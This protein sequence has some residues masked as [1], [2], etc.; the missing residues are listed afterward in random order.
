MR[1]NFVRQS[2]SQGLSSSLPTSGRKK[3]YKD[4]INV[5][6]AALANSDVRTAIKYTRKYGN[7]MFLTSLPLF[8]VDKKV[9]YKVCFWKGPSLLIF[10]ITHT[11]DQTRPDQGR[12]FL[13]LEGRE[14]ERTWKRGC[15]IR[16]FTNKAPLSWNPLII[17]LHISKRH[18]LWFPGVS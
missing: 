13:P 14:E 10:T 4:K 11:R 2:Y 3:R 18:A 12:S 1:A 7:C 5:T 17:A 9:G 8:H 16:F 6:L 15:F